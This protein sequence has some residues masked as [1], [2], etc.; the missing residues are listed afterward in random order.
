[1]NSEPPP[2]MSASRPARAVGPVSVAP[3]AGSCC[4]LVTTR[5]VTDSPGLPGGATFGFGA[6]GTVGGT[7]G[8][9]V[10][11]GA[12]GGLVGVGAVGGGG[13][14]VGGVG[15]QSPPKFAA[16]INMF[17]PLPRSEAL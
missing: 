7:V 16:E 9:F 11:G 8:G 3:V 13:V 6:S 4:A 12:G 14:G 1:M 17:G 15:V 10:V 5:G 2:A